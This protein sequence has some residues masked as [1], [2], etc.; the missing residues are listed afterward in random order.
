[1]AFN[2]SPKII[3]DG[4]VLYLDAANTRSYPTTG[5]IWSDL[6]RNNNNGT[7]INGPTFNSANGGSIVF[8]GIND[9]VFKDSPINTGDNFSVFAWIKPGNIAT[10]NAIVGNSYPYAGRIGFLLSTATGYNSNL[11]TFFL[12]IGGDTSFRIAANN[13]LTLNQWNHVSA[14]VTNGGGNILLYKNGVETQYRIGSLSSG[15]ILYTANQFYVG[16]RYSTGFEPFI[17]GISQASIYNR[18]LSATEVLQNYNA[19]KSRFGLT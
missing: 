10:R 15:T 5:T 12:S 3:T 2:Y 19:T 6:S 7:L 9:Y 18:A 1:M 14:V 16:A 8:D 17:G 11:N 13:S 4:L